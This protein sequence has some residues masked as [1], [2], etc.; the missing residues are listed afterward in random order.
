MDSDAFKDLYNGSKW[1]LGS[2]KS[3]GERVKLLEVCVRACVC[4]EE[5]TL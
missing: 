1:L 5:R 2:I 3:F 4:I